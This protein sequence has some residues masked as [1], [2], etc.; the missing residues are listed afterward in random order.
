MNFVYRFLFCNLLLWGCSAQAQP[1]LSPASSS[2]EAADELT[3]WVE[4][5]D[6]LI[7]EVEKKWWW[8][9]AGPARTNPADRNL[10]V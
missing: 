2:E 5:G 1:D 10:S 6:F 8:R 4:P 3:P 9:F 7:D